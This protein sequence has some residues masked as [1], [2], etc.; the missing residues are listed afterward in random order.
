[1]RF[2]SG[3]RCQAFSR[4]TRGRPTPTSRRRGRSG[5]GRPTAARTHE[6]SAVFQYALP[7]SRPASMRSARVPIAREHRRRRGRT[8]CRPCARSA[9][10]SLAHACDA[11]HR[12]EAL[13]AHQRLRRRARRPRRS[14]RTSCPGRSMRSPP[15]STLRAASGPRR[16]VARRARRAARRARAG[17]HRSR[18]RSG[19]PTRYA[20]T[21]STSA[22]TNA[23]QIA[24][25]TYT[26]SVALHDWPAVVERAFG[27]RERGFVDV[28][29]VAHVRR[30]LAAELELH[31]DEPVGQAARD[32]PPGRVR[33]GEAHHVD[34]GVDQRGAGRARRRRS[35]A[36]RRPERPARCIRS[37]SRSPVSVA[38]SD[39]L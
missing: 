19:S 13:V 7:T 20:P 27:D 35:R 24:S 14:A 36:R 4:R 11:D 18:R 8:R 12:A 37:T 6:R 30:V 32:A 29:V 34:V 9:S 38:C 5:G 1:M 31:A 21:T 28:D 33:T 3:A 2:Y 10:S 15:H 16:R 25:C 23:S 39:G 17:R 22:A 26:R